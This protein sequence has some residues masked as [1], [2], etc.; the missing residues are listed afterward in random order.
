MAIFEF[1]SLN[2]FSSF[3]LNFECRRLVLREIGDEN[4]NHF[5]YLVDF[6]NF[7][8]IE[9]CEEYGYEEYGYEEMEIRDDLFCITSF[10]G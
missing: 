10:K 7:S 6:P 2:G 4:N 9:M 5:S 1:S 3:S 8:Q